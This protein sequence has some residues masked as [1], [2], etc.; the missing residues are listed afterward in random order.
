MIVE[1]IRYTVPHARQDEFERAWSRAQE[2]LQEAPECLS[3]EVSHGVEE[4][5][6][7][8]VRIEWSSLEGH[9]RGF[10]QS[11]RFGPFLAAVR[12]FLD[13]ID[14]MRHYR[15]TAIASPA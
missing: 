10:R 15:R 8:V 14:E 7:Y 9:E 1:Y 4:P 2:A 13:Q 5:E 3:Y 11:A 6:H 12:P